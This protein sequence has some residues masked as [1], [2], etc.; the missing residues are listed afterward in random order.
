VVRVAKPLGVDFAAQT[1][2]TE[3][4]VSHLDGDRVI[5][6]FTE[7]HRVRF[8]FPQEIRY[9]VRQSGFDI[10]RLTSDWT[11]DN[12]LDSQSW[13]GALVARAGGR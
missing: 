1:N 6:E 12:E 3:Y 4:V 13:T 2:A 8:F 11:S 9:L 7:V 5:D 10:L